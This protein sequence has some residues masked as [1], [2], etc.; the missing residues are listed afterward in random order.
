[1][2]NIIGIQETNGWQQQTTM[3]DRHFD[4]DHLMTKPGELHLIDILEVTPSAYRTVYVQSTYN[5]EI[6]NARVAHVQQ[7]IAELTGGT[8][9][10]T[11]MVRRGRDYSRPASEVQAINELYDSSIPTP[12]LGGGGGGAAGGGGAGAALAAP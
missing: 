6:D 9:S 8:E 4:Q 3:Y 2:R 1:M 12:R 5:P 7:T 11:V 10:P